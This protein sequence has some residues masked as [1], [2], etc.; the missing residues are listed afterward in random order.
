V[1]SL[2]AV[3]TEPAVPKKQ[4]SIISSRT[5]ILYKKNHLQ[6]QP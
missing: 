3:A 5:R 1:L 4:I 2:S 6:N